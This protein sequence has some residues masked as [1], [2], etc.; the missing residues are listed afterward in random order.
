MAT[1]KEKRFNLL[2]FS[3]V[4][5]KTKALREFEFDFDRTPVKLQ[6]TPTRSFVVGEKIIVG[7]LEDCVIEEVLLD[8]MAYLYSAAGRNRENDPPLSRVYRVSWWFEIYKNVTNAHVPRLMSPSPRYQPTTG[9]I[10]SIMHYLLCGGLVCDPLYQRDYVWSEEDKD[11]LIESIFDHVPIGSV[12]LHRHAGFNHP[13]DHT[14]RKYKTLAGTEVEV[15]VCADYTISIIDG[16]QRLTTI[17]D[18][19]M[20]KRPF[21]GQYF[22]QLNIRDI[23]SFDDT[24]ITYWLLKEEETTQ[25]EIIKLFLQCNRGVSQTSQ[26][27]AKVQSLYDSMKEEENV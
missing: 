23:R 1:K 15:E 17:V 22:S 14:L 25:K 16:Q 27:L 9:V 11:S 3:V 12:L 20:D 13:D 18:F 5:A 7:L 21:K 4:D 8:G 24:P 2:P 10:G 6:P 26:H 19:V